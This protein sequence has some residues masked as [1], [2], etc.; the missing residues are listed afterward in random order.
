[1]TPSERIC[2]TREDIETSLSLMQEKNFAARDALTDKASVLDYEHLVE[3]REDGKT[4]WTKAFQSAI[5][6]HEVVIVPRTDTPYFVDKTIVIPS[7]RRIMADLD[8]VI[9]KTPEMCTVLLRNQH[10]HDGSHAPIPTDDCDRNIS[11]SGGIWEDTDPARTLYHGTYDE[12]NSMPGLDACM[13]FNNVEGL[14]LQNVKI[15][16]AGGF[17]IQI[18]D[19]TCG[20]IENITFEKT[21]ADGV[22]LN[23]N[24][25]DLIVRNISGSV[26]DDIVAFNMYDWQRSSISFG[27]IENVLCENISLDACSSYKAIR[28]LPGKYVYDDGQV[29]DCALRD[30]IIRGVRGIE[31]F[32]FYF[33]SPPYN[34][35]VGREG[36]DSGEGDNIFIEDVEMTLNKPIDS[37]EEYVGGD[38]TLGSFA[39]FEFGS[40]LGRVEMKNI[41][42]TYDREKYPTAYFACI[43]PKSIRRGATEVFD[44]DLSSSIDT[45]VLDDVEING[46]KLTESDISSYL[47]EIEFDNLYGDEGLCSK[48]VFKSITVK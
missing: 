32:K 26:A 2:R 16:Q 27:P 6:E 4:I 24:I 8:A 36:G 18:G 17:G 42:A 9:K 44:P 5:N 25:R 48:G 37:F 39:C 11:I 22:H 41:K 20:V 35:N 29:A 12:E 21:V 23:G 33:Q 1:M 46:K 10:V 19:L 38:A 47:H 30:V 43:G 14:N 34:V 3:R 15:V 13:F 45:L 28:I 7:R 40:R 31:T